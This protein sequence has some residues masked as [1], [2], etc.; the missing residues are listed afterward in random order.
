MYYREMLERL[1]RKVICES[2]Y[3]CL[4]GDKVK[5]SNR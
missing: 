2:D 1:D 4:Q 5:L 3:V